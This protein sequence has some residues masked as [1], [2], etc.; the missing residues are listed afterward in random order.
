MQELPWRN[1]ETNPPSKGR[2]VLV[3]FGPG[4]VESCY[5]E[6]KREGYCWG[7]YPGGAKVKGSYWIEFE[8]IPAPKV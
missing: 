8:E 5:Y 1:A 4:S 3:W 6:P 2:Y 7:W